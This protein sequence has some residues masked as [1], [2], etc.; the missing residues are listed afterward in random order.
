MGLNYESTIYSDRKKISEEN[1]EIELTYLVT[2]QKLQEE[3]KRYKDTFL[4]HYLFFNI[5]WKYV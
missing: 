4:K 2:M 5:C 3:L 1:G